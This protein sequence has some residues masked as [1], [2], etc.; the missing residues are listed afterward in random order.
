MATNK[1]LARSVE[2]NVTAH[3]N[4]ACYGCD[5]ASPVHPEEYL[6]VEEFA[7]DLAALAPVYHVFEFLLTGGEPLLHPRLLDV[8]DTIRASGVTEKITLMTNGVLLHKAP[9]Q[10]WS[11]ID[12]VGVSIYPGVKRTLDEG[13]I[14]ALAARHGLLLWY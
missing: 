1:I 2:V 3:C 12:K 6:S 13:Q 10:L 5:H 8:I 9:E 7:K 11:K 14:R 4:L